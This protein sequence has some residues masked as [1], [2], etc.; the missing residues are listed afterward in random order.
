[1]STTIDPAVLQQLVA[2]AVQQLKNQGAAAPCAAVAPAVPD[3]YGVFS[4]MKDA[5]DASA[6]AQHTL[7]FQNPTQRKQWVDV[8]RQTCL[9]KENMEMMSR[10]AVEETEIG[11]Y[12]DKIIKNT[13]AAQGTPG[14]EDLVTDARTGEHGL[15]LFEYC[16]FGVI[17]AITPT[18]NPTE[19]IINNS[20]CMISGGNTVVFSPHPRAKKTSVF[21]V[22]LLN[23]ALYEAGAPLNM[24]TM[25]R[26]PS[27]EATNEMIDSPKVRMVVATGGPGIVKKVLSSGKKAIGAGPGNPPVVV[28]ETANIEQAAKDIVAGSSFD[29]NVP[30]IAEKEVFAVDSIFDYLLINMKGAGAY[31]I[32]DK[33]TIEKLW[34]LVANEK[35]D[36]PKVGF[37]GKSAQ[38]ILHQIGIEVDDSKRLIIMETDK[39]HPF[40]Q[41]EMLMPILPVVRCDNVDQAIEWAY[42][43]EHGN[44][45]SAMMHSTNVAKLSKMAKLMETTIFVKNGP[46]FAGLGIGGQGYP[47]FTIAGPTGEGLTSPKSFCR[48][49]ECVMKDMFNIR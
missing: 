39:D 43:A 1:M 9:K 22:Q 6:K 31:E 34:K 19:T 44:R 4:T 10:L 27:I 26:E 13:A 5:I 40:V 14:I 45:H 25:V 11:R 29:N 35:G 20:I 21:L 47:T 3:E 49:R 15:V 12:E 30:C 17:G 41:T 37:V 48:R 33:E 18:T 8:I 42:E 23:K 46:S 24:I 16:P 36:G 38:Y 7:L 28:D 32:K 2:Q